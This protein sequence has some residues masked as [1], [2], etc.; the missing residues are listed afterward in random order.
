MRKSIFI[1]FAIFSIISCDPESGRHLQTFTGFGYGLQGADWTGT[2]ATGGLQSPINIDTNSGSCDNSL[3]FD[4]SFSSAVNITMSDEGTMMKGTGEI[5]QIY[6]TDING[7]LTGYTA[8]YFVFHAPSEHQ[9]EG[10]S[11]P[12]EMQIVHYINPLFAQKAQTTF[13]YAI[14]SI[15]FELSDTPNAMITTIN[16]TTVS[17]DPLL[18]D[19]NTLLGA[20][21]SQTVPYYAYQGSFTTPTCDEN[22][23]YYVISTPMGISSTQLALFTA[24]YAGNSNFAS[25][26]GNNRGLKDVND[27]TIKKGGVECEEQFVYFFSFLILYIFINYFIFKL[28]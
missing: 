12:L 22:V 25:G 21:Y 3:A 13:T 23:N 10:N 24:K 11:Y 15:L 16:P 26:N 4:I 2:C 14:V 19:F 8:Q 27:R 5:S 7:L 6:A 9:I 28:L 20:T 1:L 17:V 18:V